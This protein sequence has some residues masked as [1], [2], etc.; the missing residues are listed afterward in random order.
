MVENTYS[1]CNFSLM[2]RSISGKIK[3]IDTESFADVI[4][5]GDFIENWLVV[6]HHLLELNL[7]TSVR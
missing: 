3:L 7:G 2:F 1:L 4:V 5:S 6:K